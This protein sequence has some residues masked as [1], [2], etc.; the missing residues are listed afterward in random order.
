MASVPHQMQPNMVYAQ[1]MTNGQQGHL[2]LTQQPMPQQMGGQIGQFIQTSGPGFY[3]PNPNQFYPINYG[4]QVVNNPFQTANQVQNLAIQIPNGNSQQ[5]IATTP[6]QMNQPQ[7][8]G[9]NQQKGGQQQGSQSGMVKTQV[10]AN[11]TL[12]PSGQVNQNQHSGQQQPTL[13]QQSGQTYF[14]TNSQAFVQATP[15]QNQA[16]KNN[17]S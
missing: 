6:T 15:P 8:T 9:K 13:L 11:K 3:T 4:L 1:Q 17:V 16:K 7:Q 2:V 5:L 10:S 12:H 14:V